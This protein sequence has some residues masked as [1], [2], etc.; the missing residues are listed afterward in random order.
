MLT[1]RLSEVHIDLYRVLDD[2]ISIDYLHRG[3]NI[4]S[5]NY[6]TDA[7]LLEDLT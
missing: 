7:S 3:S 5:I 2:D 1:V 6:T 4:N